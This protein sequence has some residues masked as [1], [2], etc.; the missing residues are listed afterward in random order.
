M[1]QEPLRQGHHFGH[2]LYR[3]D[4]SYGT[5]MTT[6]QAA[7]IATRVNGFDQLYAAFREMTSSRVDEAWFWSKCV[8][9]F[10]AHL[11]AEVDL[12]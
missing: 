3:G 7:E 11:R 2:H 10:G 9:V 12:G 8:E 5:A 4:K 1:S 6:E